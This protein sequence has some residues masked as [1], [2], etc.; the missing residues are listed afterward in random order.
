MAKPR[1]RISKRKAQEKARSQAARKG[2]QTRRRQAKE[3]SQRAIRGWVTRRKNIRA[4]K[5]QK[6]EKQIPAPKQL[7]TKVLYD[8][9]REDPPTEHFWSNIRHLD[10]NRI[11]NILLNIPAEEGTVQ[12]TFRLAD[13][14]AFVGGEEGEEPEPFGEGETVIQDWD[15]ETDPDAF[16]STYFDHAREE[17]PDTPEGKSDGNKSL[18]VSQ[19]VLVYAPGQVSTD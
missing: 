14:D 2:W 5:K 19:M 10:G 1:G 15:T 12:V 8:G 7:V 17:L 4:A 9:H 3:R 11:S 6:R 13:A 16:W 18:L